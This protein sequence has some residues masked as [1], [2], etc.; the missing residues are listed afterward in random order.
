MAGLLFDNAPGFTQTVVAICEKLSTINIVNYTQ[1]VQVGLG[2]EQA[3]PYLG[4]TPFN[5]PLQT[6]DRRTPFIVLFGKGEV[7]KEG[8]APLLDTPLPW[9]EVKPPFN[10]N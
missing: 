3:S 2:H 7:K 5:P 8:L 6:V 10:C 4:L 1:Y 9:G